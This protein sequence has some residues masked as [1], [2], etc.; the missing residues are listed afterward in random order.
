VLTEA[1]ERYPDSPVNYVLR[2]EAL[3]DGGDKDLAAD[4]FMKALALAEPRA[5]TA[6]WGYINR[7]LAD[8]ARDGL[9]R[10]HT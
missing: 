4:D 5:D 2:G 7:A 10:A 1:I 3:L 6:N 8:R 9:R